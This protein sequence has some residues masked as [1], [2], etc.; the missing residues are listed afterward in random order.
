MTEIKDATPDQ[1]WVM[2]PKAALDWLNGEAPDEDGQWFGDGEDASP[3]RKR[4]WWR[5][6]FRAML[7]ARPVPSTE[8][9][10]VE[11]LEREAF[12]SDHQGD[13]IM[14]KHAVMLREAASALTA[15]QARIAAMEKRY[16]AV[17]DE[18]YRGWVL[19]EQGD[20]ALGE[21]QARLAT[22]ERE[23]D[24][25]REALK[26]F[27]LVASALDNGALLM[28][29]KYEDHEPI[30]K[31]DQGEPLITMGQLRAARSALSPTQPEGGE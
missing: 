14:R 29:W 10:L 23:R 4:Y 30:A 21:M 2:V 15:A 19:K 26:P 3:P 11:R 7:A 12:L 24:E 28:G 6:K 9:C 16:E 1:E 8:G 25:A 17:S 13:V 27:A 5:S 22:A 31:G 20:K 18:N